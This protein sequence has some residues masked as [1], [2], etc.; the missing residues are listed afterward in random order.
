ME[1]RRRIMIWAGSGS[2]AAFALWTW[3]VCRIGVQPIGPN[4]S[5]VGFGE[6][7]HWFHQLTGV[8][9]GL[10]TV[11]DWLTDI[12]GGVLLSAGLVLLYQGLSGQTLTG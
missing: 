9:M 10:Y 6:M 11:T 8:H 5:R 3:A 12:I 2:L 4:S 1:K 7:N